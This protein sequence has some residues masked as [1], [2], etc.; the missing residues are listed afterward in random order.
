MILAQ[1]FILHL[2][3]RSSVILLINKL[4]TFEKILSKFCVDFLA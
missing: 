3:V 4:I 1:H 2:S